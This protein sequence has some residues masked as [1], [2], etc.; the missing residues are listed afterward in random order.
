MN[1]KLRNKKVS[2][3]TLGEVF[4]AVK[5]EIIKEVAEKYQ[6]KVISITV[7]RRNIMSSRPLPSVRNI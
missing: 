7:S 6:T 1:Q 5:D 4:D 2:E 3:L